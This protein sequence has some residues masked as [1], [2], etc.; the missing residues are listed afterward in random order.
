[1]FKFSLNSYATRFG[2]SPLSNTH[3]GWPMFPSPVIFSAA[4]VGRSIKGH[5]LEEDI[6]C[7][8]MRPCSERT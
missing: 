1:M 2:V 5:V 7:S 4:E 6:F 3:V 8:F